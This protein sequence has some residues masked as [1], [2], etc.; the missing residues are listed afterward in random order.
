MR[1]RLLA[2]LLASSAVLM[3]LVVVPSA[4]G[5]T[6]PC[7]GAT[8][9]VF[10]VYASP[11]PVHVG[12]TTVLSL[13]LTGLGSSTPDT[14]TWY[15][16]NGGN[17]SLTEVQT[18]TVATAAN[19]TYNWTAL[20]GY[21][22]WEGTVVGATGCAVT[23]LTGITEIGGISV[24]LSQSKDQ[25]DEGATVSYSATVSGGSSYTY[26]WTGCSSSTATCS[27]IFTSTGSF[28]VTVQATDSAGS[29]NAS[30]VT[31]RVFPALSVRLSAIPNSAD[32]STVI[33]WTAAATGGSGAYEFGGAP[34]GGAISYAGTSGAVTVCGSQSSYTAPSELNCSA[35]MGSNV[36]P[37][38]IQS[39]ACVTDTTGESACGSAYVDIHADPSAVI[40]GPMYVDVGTPATW[41]GFAINGTAPF[42]YTWS[43]GA[44]TIGTA[45][46]LTYSFSSP[47]QYTLKLQ[48]ADSATRTAEAN[49]SV[50]VFSD[51]VVSA[52]NNLTSTGGKADIGFPVGFS[53]TAS[54]GVGGYTYRW[55]LNGVV[56]GNSSS[57]SRSFGSPGTY[58]L[59]AR[60]TDSAG[61]VESADTTV[62]IVANP[63]VTASSTPSVVDSGSTAQIQATVTGG[64]GAVSYS[65]SIAGV[66]V[67]TSPSFSHAFGSVGNYSVSV[68]VT[69][70]DGH[71]A[72]SQ[73]TVQVVPDPSVTIGITPDPADVGIAVVFVG[74][75]SGGVGPYNWT[76]TIGSH[77]RYGQRVVVAFNASGA[78][79]VRLELSDSES[80]TATSSTSLAVNADP[81]VQV[82]A[83]FGTVDQGVNDTFSAETVGGSPPINYTWSVNGS[84]RGWG[85]QFVVAFGAIGHYNVSVVATDGLGLVSRGYQVV[86]VTAA[87]EVE[88]LGPT[89]VDY[90][91]AASWIANGS[92][93]TAP[94]NYTW[95]VQQS[96]AGYG[97]IF[98]HS[99][100]AV[101]SLTLGLVLTD[102]QG[103]RAWANVT[104]VVA[105]FP[106]AVVTAN[107][108][109][110][111]L[112][113]P[114][115][116]TC[117]VSGGSAPYQYEWIVGGSTA[118]TES[119]VTFT[120][121]RAGSIVAE[122]I[123]TD[124]AGARA[125]ANDTTQI[126][127]SPSVSFAIPSPN[128]DPN[129]TVTLTASAS[130][131]TPAYSYV[132]MVDGS[133]VS[134]S[135]TANLTFGAPG[136]YTVE[137]EVIDAVG[138]IATETRSVA[139]QPYPTVA[140]EPSSTHIDVGINESLRAQLR[141]GVGPY[142][143]S[144]LVGGTAYNSTAVSFAWAAAGNYTVTLVV[145]DVFG[146][147]ASATVQISV[148]PDPTIGVE[149]ASSLPVVSVPYTLTAVV[150]GGYGPYQY[151]WTF[152]SGQQANG[153]QISHVFETGG[154]R[155]YQ[156]R[157]TDAGGF[158]GVTSF[159]IVV[160][161]FVSASETAGSG[162]APLTE[163]FLASALGGAGYAYNWTFGN[164]NYSVSPSPEETFGAGNWT[165]ELEVRAANG[166][167]GFANLTVISLP[168]P[169]VVTWTPAQ[170][171]TV[172][173]EVN[174]TA[175]PSWVAGQNHTSTWVFPNGVQATGDRVQH[176]FRQ[177]GEFQ[178]VLF[179]FS[180]SGGNYSLQLTVDMRPAPP[181]A[182]IGG[183]SAVEPVGT[184]IALSGGAST[185]PDA[186]ISAWQWSVSS[187]A[188]S[189][190]Y[191]GATVYV[192]ANTTGNWSVALTVT[193]SLG[194]VGSAVA[195]FRVETSGTSASITL[196]VRSTVIESTTR[197]NVSV[198]STASPISAV[199]ALLSGSV[200]PITRINGT[201]SWANYTFGLDAGSYS[202][203]TYTIEVV[204]FAAN[205]D[206]N[207][208][209]VS[210]TVS[211]ISGVTSFD[212]VAM[213]GGPTNFLIIVLTAI[214]SVATVASLRNRDTTNI[215]IDGTVLTGK[216]GGELRLKGGKPPKGI[217]KRV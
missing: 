186:N 113:I 106:T 18:K 130:N 67:S 83:E 135:R 88:I 183:L 34:G 146:H 119:S 111:D 197:Y 38:T 201:S 210:W 2:L 141:G 81:Q 6:G 47:G 19:Y 31:T 177:Y 28:T 97:A 118:G 23:H 112:G 7:S 213:L 95:E 208:S 108:T 73:I 171:I 75:A 137:L 70:Q 92:L 207:S 62:T 115:A 175:A 166:A 24:S 79:S 164:G 49:L 42:N 100:S 163:F 29:T 78:H 17:G 21:P 124:A 127:P 59:I 151:L 153:S 131:G 216:P 172:E 203:G 126:N 84:V 198:R 44:G 96:V 144:W 179:T 45:E 61:T 68:T 8:P 159:D 58:T 55:V 56:V 133:V 191:S 37:G 9:P 168:P 149:H 5:A 147:D 89:K 178:T 25:V 65:W 217:Q 114:V 16:Q 22:D 107:V 120:G 161:L 122:C 1:V 82:S 204:A 188:G 66:E 110:T 104:V 196:R 41:Q 180:Y 123:V 30:S 53:S 143:Y 202:P 98:R 215:D 64:T 60:V 152:G 14:V 93:G 74:N 138:A 160:R 162:S 85:S 140:I 87:P 134:R 99:F 206:S 71:T 76:W 195:P 35:V 192:D 170:N 52:T 136:S 156:V 10:A 63:S 139:V 174:F 157:I 90:G 209:S 54:G 102:S 48:V 165:V 212:L 69:D 176:E 145:G 189:L 154:P 86:T 117:Q 46:N 101:G 181:S 116:A 194:A 36:Q 4:S 132:W 43:A 155:T 199:D 105:A 33:E 12:A 184:L 91:V 142:S 50:T 158:S 15:V 121:S 211:E 193:D 109:A 3:G 173:T 103:G 51:P 94:Y 185:S 27:H 129:T 167:E 200:L 39:T 26:R 125:T 77:T 72:P 148:Y 80:V 20:G 40:G 11:N 57:L 214:G 169:V 190:A 128:L 187:P 205:G 32:V 13:D 182:V 150:S